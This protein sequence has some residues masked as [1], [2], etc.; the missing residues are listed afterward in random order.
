MVLQY[1]TVRKYGPCRYSKLVC[2]LTSSGLFSNYAYCLHL[3]SGLFEEVIHV[4]L[5]GVNPSRLGILFSCLY[6]IAI[7]I[8]IV[9]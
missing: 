1:G 9:L 7:L 8:V 5:Y 6:A 4:H 2:W 3:A